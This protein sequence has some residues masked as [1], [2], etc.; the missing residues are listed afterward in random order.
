MDGVSEA[1][2]VV[3]DGLGHTEPRQ[4]VPEEGRSEQPHE[5]RQLLHEQ[6]SR[7]TKFAVLHLSDKL[8]RGKIRAV[9]CRLR[10]STGNIGQ[11]EPF[12][13]D[14]TDYDIRVRG[15]G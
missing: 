14:L 7:Q 12:S 10:D 4:S 3:H 1:N 6:D 13:A 15:Q 11:G 8:E 2:H 5:M 9:E